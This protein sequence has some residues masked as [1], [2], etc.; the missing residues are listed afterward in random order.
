MRTYI[1][2]L[3]LLCSCAAPERSPL[4]IACAANMEVGI[5]S[6][7]KSYMEKEGVEVKVVSAASGVLA[8]QI[9]SGAPYDLFLSADKDLTDELN[10]DGY[11]S[12]SEEYLKSELV[13]INLTD[14]KGASVSELLLSDK[15]KSIGIAD[16][17]VAPF[18]KAAKN[19]LN[20]V[21]L[22]EQIQ[23]KVV[24]AESVSQLNMYVE[25]GNVDVAF[26]GLSFL[27]QREYVYPFLHLENHPESL[28]RQYLVEV[29]R[30]KNKHP[31]VNDFHDYLYS[32]EAIAILKYFGY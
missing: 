20:A 16:P 15:T 5:D 21:Q 12:S 11:T 4:T 23:S 22:W 17:E 13:C 9:R 8:T 7:A 10:A 1:W 30:G 2:A 14:Y 31:Q 6:I 25:T 18:G 19:Y 27:A 28:I 24:Y 26:T 32:E 3:V 29:D